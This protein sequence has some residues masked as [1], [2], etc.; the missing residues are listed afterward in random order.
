[1]LTGK[2]IQNAGPSGK[3]WKS[4]IPL[5]TALLAVVTLL[6][7][8]TAGAK[9]TP[10]PP[11]PPPYVPPSTP[12]DFQVT[13]VTETSV[14]FAWSPSTPGTDRNFVYVIDELSPS[15]GFTVNVGDVTSS[16]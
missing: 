10:K 7:A 16:N 9:V 5:V 6:V 11:P 12:G 1:M 13:A 4:A 15:D 3:T 14:S 2:R 8:F